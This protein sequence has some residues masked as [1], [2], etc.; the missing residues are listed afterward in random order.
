MTISYHTL[1]NGLKCVHALS[2]GNA[3]YF[4]A[5]ADTGSR[6]EAPGREGLAHF[7][8]HTIF[9]GTARRRSWHIINRMESVGGELNAYTTKESTAVYSLFPNGNIDRSME[10]V[11]DLITGSRFPRAEIDREREVVADEINSYLDMP[12]EAVYDDFDELIFAGNPLAHNI[13]GTLHSLTAFT[14]EICREYLVSRYTPGRMALFY[15]GGEHPDRVFRM[16]ERYFGHMDH[17]DLP[18]AR[19]EP[20]DVSAFC[21]HK[22]VGSHQAHNLMGVRIGS[23][24]SPDRYA[25]ALLTNI[26]GGPGMNSLLN[27]ELRERRG[28]VYTV[29]ASTALYTDCGLL[30]IYFGCDPDDVSACRRI[31]DRK[32]KELTDAPLCP[33][34]LESAKRQYLGQLKVSADNRENRALSIGRAMLYRG[35]V[36]SD[37]EIAE[38]IAAVTP[39]DVQR[40]ASLASP[41]RMSMLTLD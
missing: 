23:M 4:G 28:L 12:S 6:D 39:Y 38:A 30:N 8:E 18:Y 7:V 33:R 11:A 2:A 1:P 27:V 17:D 24:F 14:P 19:T 40:A 36:A 5:L 37:A 31:I 35:R 25:V 3:E 13:L 41:G 9:K 15:L 32:L 29:E 22:N 10:L 34:R 20:H 21:E 26:L 16:A